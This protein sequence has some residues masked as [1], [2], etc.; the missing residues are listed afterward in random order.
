[1]PAQPIVIEALAQRVVEMD[2]QPP[3]DAVDVFEADGQELP[4]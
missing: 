4:P 1:M 3:V 2:V